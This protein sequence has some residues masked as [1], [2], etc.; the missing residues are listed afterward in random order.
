VCVTTE[1]VEA[2]G[3]SPRGYKLDEG[4]RKGSNP[5]SAVVDGSRLIPPS[6]LKWL[7]LDTSLDLDV[8]RVCKPS[9][10]SH[11]CGP[12]RAESPH[13]SEAMRGHDPES[14]PSPR[15]RYRR[16]IGSRSRK[17]E[18]YEDLATA[19]V[20]YYYCRALIN[21]PLMDKSCDHARRSCN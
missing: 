4:G 3:R 18:L 13:G 11:P 1:R 12:P 2:R 14:Y 19:R 10:P 9:P 8:N 6:R 5:P 15:A 16:E 7:Q 21:S 17:A 20:Y